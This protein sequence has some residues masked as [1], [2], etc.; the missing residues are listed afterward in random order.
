MF[1]TSVSSEEI[2]ALVKMQLGDDADWDIHSFAVTGS[3]GNDITFS[4]PRV[5]VSV[6]YQ[7]EELVKRASDLVDRVIAGEE[8]TDE[9]VAKETPEP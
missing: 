2:A 9:D 3:T 8:I 1:V 5:A 6:M 4:I 7:D